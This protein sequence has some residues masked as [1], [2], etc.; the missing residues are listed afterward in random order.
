MRVLLTFTY[1]ISLIEWYKSGYFN[2]EIP[3]YNKI[4]NKG[5][6]D[7]VFLTYGNQKDYEYADLLG[8]IK[9]N[10][11]LDLINSKVPLIKHVKSLFLPVKLKELFKNVDLIK[12]VQVYGSWV[13]C[14]A[15]ILYRRKLIIK[16]G[17]GW[18]AFTRNVSV[19]K[20]IKN[21]IKYLLKYAFI[22]INELVSFKL[23]DGIIVTSDY[24]IP[25]I[26]KYYRL[27]R[28]LKKNKIRLIYNSI[29]IETFK[30]IS[31]PKK[32]KYI[33]FIGNLYAAKNVMNL[34]EAFK[35]IPQFTLD[36]IGEGHDKE[37]MI[38]RSEELDLNINFLGLFPNNKLP[39]ILNQY[40]IFILPS[41]SEGN[42]KVLLEAMSCG[43]ACIG[44]NIEGINNIIK[45][46]VN[47]FL[48]NTDPESI[49]DAILTLYKNEKLREK[50]GKNARKFILDNCSLKVNIGKEI[51]FYRDILKK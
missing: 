30:S 47:G 43:L 2:R 13:P 48:C 7:Y 3:F 31:V 38:K 37:K 9:I 14:I 4:I 1:N 41:I 25:F 8:N 11:A 49:R 12:T 26:V 6:I 35:Y 28:K 33:L 29:D 27:K 18:L 17:F 16:S 40:Q 34:I 23:A 5:K 36:I 15:K 46:K 20:G 19:K 24:D 51:S 42:P 39:E 21:Y 45:H 22:F 10:P 32:N 44:S 50:L